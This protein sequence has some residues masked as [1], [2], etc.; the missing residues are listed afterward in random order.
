MILKIK[1]IETQSNE[2]MHFSIFP[3]NSV[4]YEG[5]GVSDL[6]EFQV[7]SLV[8]SLAHFFN[9]VQYA[10]C[11]CWI[12]KTNTPTNKAMCID[13]W[14]LS[15]LHYAFRIIAKGSRCSEKYLKTMTT[16]KVPDHKRSITFVLMLTAIF[17]INKY[18]RNSLSVLP[19]GYYST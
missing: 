1:N 16:A 12:I 19:S 2:Q 6:Y 5:W 17:F 15:C 9:S 11:V 4:L 18:I 14:F 10:A 7:C 3:P 8:L 13:G